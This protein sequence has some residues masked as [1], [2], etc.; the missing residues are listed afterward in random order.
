MNLYLIHC[1]FYDTDICDG[2]YESHVNLFTVAE[3][4][5]AAKKRIRLNEIFKQKKMHIDGI[6]EVLAVEGY[7][8]SVIEDQTLRG[9]SQVISNLHRDL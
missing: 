5:D 4:V 9:K 1:G 3:D 6:Q 8:I 2:I 7:R